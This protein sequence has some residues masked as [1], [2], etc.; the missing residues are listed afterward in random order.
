[1]TRPRYARPCRLGVERLE[2]R[3]VPA[4]FTVNST[5]DN[6]TPGDGKLTLREAIT[7]ANNHAGADVIVVPAGEFKIALAGAGEDANATGDF[8]ITDSVTMRGAGR[9]KTVVDGQQLDRVFHGPTQ[10]LI[11]VVF[12]GMTI[13]NGAANPGGGGGIL[14]NNVDLV[15]RT[16]AVTGNRSAGSGG[17]I[18]QVSLSMGAGSVKVIDSNVARNVA[19]NN[20]SGGGIYV[21]SEVVFTVT[22]STIRRNVARGGGGGIFGDTANLTGCT[23]NGNSA[24]FSGGGID[25]TTVTLRDST[26]S[27]N[28][29]G[30]SG[31]GIS[32]T[33]ANLTRSTVSGNAAAGQGGGIWANDD[34][35]LVNCT[36][37]GNS[38]GGQGGGVW[39]EHTRLIRSTATGNRAGDQ[40]G[41][42]WANDDA[43]LMNSTLRGNTAGTF[44]GGLAVTFGTGNLFNCTVEGNRAGNSGGGIN[45]DQLFLEHCTV[46]GNTAAL[47]GGGLAAN[48]T[49]LKNATISGN[50]AG[51]QGG[52][53]WAILASLR[54][55]TVVENVASNGG[56]LFHEPGSVFYV[57]NTIVALNV[58]VSGA[59]DVSGDFDNT[60]HNLIGIDSGSSGFSNANGSIVGTRSNPIDP[61]LGALA[62]NGGPTKTHRLLA[63][64]LAIDAGEIDHKNPLKTDQRGFPRVK[65][66]NGDGR[67]VVDIG[68]FE[69]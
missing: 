23:V 31:G 46:N 42:V 51:D 55:C 14:V 47:D 36:L 37:S 54:N 39:A 48:H 43:S 29:A 18:S 69:R 25:C 7:R 35:S 21:A 6:L 20:T 33:M 28:S 30:S 19:D 49:Q 45:A 15:V 68:A 58:D 50:T 27:G 17:G 4:T 66:G 60:G 38:A 9:G 62:F 53:V 24:G 34:A 64:S 3:A 12:Q 44:G 32:A 40:G 59:P 11:K 1:M 57:R 56:G 61:K 16:C 8:D 5:L 22:G 65:D 26:I 10:A 41:G 2:D 63:S 13:R 67:A 52:G